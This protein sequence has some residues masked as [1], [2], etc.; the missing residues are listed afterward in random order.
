[1]LNATLKDGMNKHIKQ[2]MLHS[3]NRLIVLEKSQTVEMQKFIEDV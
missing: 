1:M 2:I 3:N